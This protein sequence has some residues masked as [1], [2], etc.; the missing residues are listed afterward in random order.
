MHA[1]HTVHAMPDLLLKLYKNEAHSGNIP[2][3]SIFN[4]LEFCNPTHSGK[5]T[6][7]KRLR[8]SSEMPFWHLKGK[9]DRQHPVI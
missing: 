9:R 8:G 6:R 5:H 7:I 3:N 2:A 1:T 4:S